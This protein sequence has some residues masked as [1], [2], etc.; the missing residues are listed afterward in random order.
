MSPRIAGRS[1]LALT[2][3]AV[4]TLT[5]GCSDKKETLTNPTPYD[6]APLLSQFAHEVVVPTYEDLVTNATTL[7]AAILDYAA[8]STSQSKLNAAAAAWVATRAPWEK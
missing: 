6:Y 8:D 7:H 5:A 4:L 2:L 1:T 3:L